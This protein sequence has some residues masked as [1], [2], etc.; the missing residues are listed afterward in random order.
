MLASLHVS[1]HNAR[2]LL[3][4]DIGGTNTRL[5]LLDEKDAAPGSGVEM[6]ERRRDQHVYSSNAYP[7]IEAV[8]ADFLGRTGSR[9]E[10]AAFGVAGPV[11]DGVARATNLDWIV[12]T[13]SLQS[14][15]GTRR[16]LVKNDLET[17]GIGLLHL[18]PASFRVL[19]EGREDK[20]GNAALIA[21][22]TG[23]GKA[24]LVREANGSLRPIPSEGGHAD[25]GAR[26]EEQDDVVKW[27]R[28]RVGQVSH[29]R[30][31]AGPAI[32][33][34]HAYFAE[35]GVAEPET[36]SRRIADAGAKAPAEIA[37]AALERESPRCVAA[38][39]FF[40]TAYGQSA[41]ALAL[42]ALATGGMY[43]G[44]GIAPKILPA[45]VDGRFMAAFRQH[46]FLEDL[47]A[48]I[49][50]KVALDDRASLLG[51]AISAARSLS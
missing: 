6:L 40:V 38:I 13:A 4:G 23:L 16:V 22:G 49:P 27:M 9:V 17:T 48:A 45:L 36:I 35:R 33:H 18:P 14:D 34:L 20:E 37:K 41:Q 2:M 29:E 12:D 3:A 32:H 15:L 8:V 44:G 46:P 11:I 50:V 7:S 1:R 21:A 51:A 19:N 43:L 31:V 28:R 25:F 30:L 47:L 10:A 39:E 42:T 24:I 5:L 26:S